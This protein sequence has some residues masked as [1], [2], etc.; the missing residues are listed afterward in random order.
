[1]NKEKKNILTLIILLLFV[2][3]IFLHNQEVKEHII[4]GTELWLNKVFPSL[5]PMFIISELLIAYQFPDFLAKIF[6]IPF[7]KIFHA[8]PYGAFAFF[9][10]LISGTPSSAY[11]IKKLM[12]ENKITEKDANH[13]LSFTFF[14]NPLFLITM[15]SLLFPNHPKYII[16]I[17]CIH[18]LT[19]LIIGIVLRP[20]EIP[21]QKTTFTKNK[22]IQL[23]TLL[24]NAIKNA[25]NTLLLILGTICFYLMISC[26][27]KPQN[28]TLQLFIKGILELTQGLNALSLFSSSLLIKACLAISFISFGGLSIHTQI[29][30]IIADTN[31]SYQM[32]L[33]GRILHVMFSILFL[34]IATSTGIIT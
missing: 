14:S 29:Q 6:S 19:N 16:G 30:S 7:Q 1:M 2:I 21:N 18:Y 34:L 24:S 9:M 13:L 8:T 26:F 4:F 33:K 3:L 32:F 23:G 27:I 31:I 20:K 17:I 15:L 22:N 25:M 11:I 10:S 28:E 5:F 12:I